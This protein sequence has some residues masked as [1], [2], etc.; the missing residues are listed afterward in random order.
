MAGVRN[1]DPQ[2]RWD[3]LVIG[4]GFGG[5]VSALRLAEKGYRVLV[6]EAGKWREDTAHPRTNN[7]PFR[8]FWRPTLFCRGIQRVDFYRH[9]AILS[10]AG[11]GGGSLMYANTLLEPPE[12]FYE[13]DDLPAGHDWK[14]ELAPHFDTASRMLGKTEHDQTTGMDTMLLAA[15]KERGVQDTFY[16]VPVGVFLGEAD[17][18]VPDPYFDGDGPDRTGCTLCGGCMIGCRVGAKNVLLKNYLYLAMGKGAEIQAD[19]EVVDVR[20]MAEGG[21]EVTARNPGPFGRKRY[22]YTTDN[23]VLAAGVLGTLRLLFDWQ[24]RDRLHVS[25]RLGWNVRTNSESLLGVRRLEKDVNLA[26]GVAITSG[27]YI[28]DETHVEV[29]RYPEGANIMCGMT[30]VLTDA[31]TG[32]SRIVLFLKNVLRHPV[33]AFRALW[34]GKWAKQ[35]CILLVMQSRDN[36]IRFVGKR[37]LSGGVKLKSALEPGVERVPVYIPQANAF[38]RRMAKLVGGVAMSNIYEVFFGTPLTA[39]ILGG[40]PMGD[41]EAEGVVDHRHRMFGEEGVMVVD[42]SVIPANLGVNPSLSITAMAERAMSFIPVR[43]SGE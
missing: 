7:T 16:R 35:S 14:V 27:V 38:A 13:S 8:F 15:A 36:R 18:T 29:V 12:R 3:Y 42:G 43:D 4:S 37:K 26:E 1:T 17:E 20:R 5:S 39:H 30:S 19:R 32:K 22:R 10:G 41:S 6:L 28:D 33:L 2:E 23:I 34:P 11:V 31:E 9:T 24:Q 25:D 40:C 21:Y